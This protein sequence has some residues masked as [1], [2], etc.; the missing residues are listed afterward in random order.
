MTSCDYFDSSLLSIVVRLRHEV[1]LHWIIT[2]KL[3]SR[4]GNGFVVL[5]NDGNGFVVLKLIVVLTN[6]SI[7]EGTF[8]GGDQRQLPYL[9]WCHLPG[10]PIKGIL[11]G[12]LRQSSN[13]GLSFTTT[14]VTS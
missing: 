14:K 12:E 6:T 9:A 3:G 10:S 11:G 5:K 2:N 4:D 1:P 13:L 7:A 8:G